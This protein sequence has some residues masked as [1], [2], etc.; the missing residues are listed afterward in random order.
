MYRSCQPG[1]DARKISPP[2]GSGEVFLLDIPFYRTA[3]RLN[4]FAEKFNTMVITP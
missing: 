1:L 4:L 3:H 2:G